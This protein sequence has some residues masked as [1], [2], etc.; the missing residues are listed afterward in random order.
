M[1]GHGER[2]KG[3]KIREV[4]KVDSNLFLVDLVYYLHPSS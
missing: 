1:V 2:E 3:D 4:E